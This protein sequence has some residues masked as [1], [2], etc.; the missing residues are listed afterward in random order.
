MGFGLRHIALL[1]VHIS[2]VEQGQRVTLLIQQRQIKR[3]FGIF[4]FL[5][6]QVDQTLRK[7]DSR[8]AR[9]LF[10][11]N[12]QVVLRLFKVIKQ[13]A[14]GDPFITIRQIGWLQRNRFGI[15]IPRLF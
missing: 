13:N 14:D 5:G 7:S 8:V 12:I 11:Q 9:Q 2:Q 1:I 4:Q 6:C 15:G 3:R 10:L